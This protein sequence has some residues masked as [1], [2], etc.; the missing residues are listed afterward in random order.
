MD[1]LRWE[2]E[3]SA[4]IVDFQERRRAVE[5]TLEMRTPEGPVPVRQLPDQVGETMRKEEF[6]A[7]KSRQG[8]PPSLRRHAVSD[9]SAVRDL[10]R[11]WEE[12]SGAGSSPPADLPLQGSHPPRVQ[13]RRGTHAVRGRT[14]DEQGFTDF[15]RRGDEARG[16]RQ[17]MWVAGPR[18]EDPVQFPTPVNPRFSSSGSEEIGRAHV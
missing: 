13:I 5:A 12:R 7:G 8:L 18:Q 16:R 1:Q 10:V 9:G 2:M 15:L 17:P 4:R 11:T 14:L 6:A 3:D